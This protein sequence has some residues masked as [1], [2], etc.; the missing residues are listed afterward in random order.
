MKSHYCCAHE[1]FLISH[2][3][4]DGS[5]E[6]QGVLLHL[7]QLW[8]LHPLCWKEVM[9]VIKA[10][11]SAALCRSECAVQNCLTLSRNVNKC[12]SDI[13]MDCFY[14][15]NNHK[16]D[17]L[18]PPRSSLPVTVNKHNGHRGDELSIQLLILPTCCSLCAP[19]ASQL[20]GG[21]TAKE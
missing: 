6:Y 15:N 10:Y 16:H 7:Q 8:L 12:A 2:P 19:P 5:G 9:M 3:A 1:L 17:L 4:H 21:K 20:L 13:E 18:Y 11:H 14:I